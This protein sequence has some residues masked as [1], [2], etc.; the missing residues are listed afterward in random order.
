MFIHIQSATRLEKDLA[1]I[2]RAI[3]TQY[4]F[5]FQL[6]AMTSRI[7]TKETQR[8][9]AEVRKTQAGQMII[10]QIIQRTNRYKHKAK[11]GMQKA[12]EQIT[13]NTH[14]VFVGIFPWLLE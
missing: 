12:A 6:M 13:K 7:V 8:R 3:T 2:S 14:T 5:Q 11:E 9:N 1:Y 10:P 4:A